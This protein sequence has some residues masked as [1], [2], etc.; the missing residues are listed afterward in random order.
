MGSETFF[1]AYVV[2]VF[3]NPPNSDDADLHEKKG[4]EGIY[5]LQGDEQPVDE[6]A[7]ANNVEVSD[8]CQ[9]YKLMILAGKIASRK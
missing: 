1:K 8:V 6:L 5:Y 2:S 9:Q 7:A 3:G 4:R